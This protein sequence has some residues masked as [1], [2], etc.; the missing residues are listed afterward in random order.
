MPIDVSCEV[1][2]ER[3]RSAVAAYIE[4]PT[5]DMIWIRALRRA[6]PLADGTFGKG[7]RVERVAS[8]MGREITYVTEVVGYEPGRLVHMATVSGP[9]PMLG[10]YTVEDAGPAAP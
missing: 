7:S 2:I 10:T 8:M 3:P 5:H 4:D 9:L 1:L 6:T